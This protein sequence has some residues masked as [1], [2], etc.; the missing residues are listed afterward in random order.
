MQ[1]NFID[2]HPVAKQNLF[3]FFFN[4]LDGHN[5]SK[6]KNRPQYLIPRIFFNVMCPCDSNVNVY[7]PVSKTNNL[8]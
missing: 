6:T 8:K 3:L 4:R 2:S 7:E 5:S 1:L